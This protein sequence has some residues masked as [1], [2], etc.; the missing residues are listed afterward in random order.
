M[1]NELGNQIAR[2]ASNVSDALT[3]IGNKGVTIPTG[4]NSDDLADLIAQINTGSGSAIV[5]EDTTDT[6]GGTIREITAVSLAG[7][8]VSSSVLYSGY[9][10]H[11]S[12]GNAIVGTASGGSV[13]V[14]SDKTYTV[15]ASGSQT[16]NPDAGYDAMD[17]VALTVPSQTLPTT[18]SSS[19]T[20]GYT[21]KAT[22]GRSTSDQYINIPTGYNATGAYYKV[23][24]VT[25]GSATPAASISGTSATV[26]TGTN[27]LTLSK[28]VSNT[29]QV[30]AGYISSGTAGNSSVSLTASVTT[31]AAAT[32]TPTTSNQTIASGTYLTGTQTISGDANLVAG[33]IKSGTTIFGVTGTYTGGGGGGIGTLL[34][35]TSIGSVSTTSTQ[36]ASLNVSLSVSGVNNYDLLIV[37]SSV[38]TITNNRHTAT[39]GLIFLTASSNANTKN[40]ATVATAKLNTKISSSAVTTTNASTTAYGIY[41]NSCSISDGT[42]TIPMYRRYNSTSTG[43]I[44][45]TYTARVYG[46]NL[47]DLIGG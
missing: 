1:S 15:S 27:T 33:N 6:H 35:T 4:S 26:S 43:T 19:A 39:V 44:N 42:A 45:G 37:E 13:N 22:V 32:I 3:A 16:I 9:T 28:T 40:G 30:T 29:P 41:P 21:S 10:A 36:A 17:N 11:D 23:N 24:A 46:V 34:N 8:T 7:D 5:I 31:K 12:M 14:Q 25:N 38:N 18:T 2:I 20:S 47:I